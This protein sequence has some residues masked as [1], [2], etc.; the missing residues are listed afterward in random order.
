VENAHTNTGGVGRS[1]RMPFLT[2]KKREKISGVTF[3]IQK[4]TAERRYTVSLM[5]L[6]M[7]VPLL[8]TKAHE[9]W[10]NLTHCHPSGMLAIC[11]TWNSTTCSEL[12]LH[13]S[14]IGSHVNGCG[15]PKWCDFEL[16]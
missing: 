14:Q 11:I 9:E 4:V 2:P 16:V 10:Q 3:S 5:S 15:L 1:D 12:W 13:F 8:R 6:L 7:P